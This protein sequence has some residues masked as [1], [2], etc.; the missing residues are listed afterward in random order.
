MK[1][2]ALRILTLCLALALC[3]PAAAESTADVS[4]TVGEKLLKQ[5]E[6]GSG[7]TGTLTFTATA[8]AGR[9]T[10]AVT[11]L[12]PMVFDIGYI[13]VREDLAAKTPAESRMTIALTDGES[14][15]GNA[16]LAFKGGAA[17]LK[18]VL[19]GDSWYTLAGTAAAGS[20]TDTGTV[21]KSA[22]G[23]LAGTAMPGLS[24]FAAGLAAQL[25]GTDFA[26]LSTALEP[27]AT[28]VDL[29]IEAYRQN[30]L[31]GKADDGSTTMTVDYDIPAAA[32]K[33]Q[34]KQMVMDML[35]DQDLLPR[36]TAL[37][38]D[39]EAERFL[40]PALQSYYF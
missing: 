23:L 8:V 5:L 14:T 10:E 20:D 6:A 7:F 15:A 22:Q 28:K 18:S 40:N 1:K 13:F 27:Y 33:A 16:E 3:L 24:T 34:L 9:E 35:A 36:L 29:W 12:K 38:P 17:Y 31:L 21:A 30:A 11:T 25:A 4:Y 26:K 19:T 32:V 2:T 37:L 39:G